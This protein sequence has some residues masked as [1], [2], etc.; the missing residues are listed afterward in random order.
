MRIESA[1]ARNLRIAAIATGLGSIVFS[2]LALSDIIHDSAYLVAGFTIPSVGL[3]CGLPVA[4]AGFARWGSVHVVRILARAHTVVT[5]LVIFL[6]VPFEQFGALPAGGAP[7]ILNTVSVAAA[8]AVVAWPARVVWAYIILMAA[9]GAALR[10]VGLGTGS[11]I[12]PLEDG[13][14]ML[15]FSVVIAT[16]LIVAL[17]I[18]RDRDSA[19]ELAIIDARSASELASRARQRSRFAALVHDDVLTTL[20]AAARSTSRTPAVEQSA[21]RAISRLDSFMSAPLSEVPLDPTIFEI[22]VRAAATDVVDGVKFEGAFH[23]FDGLIPSQVALAITGAIAEAARNSVHHAGPDPVARSLRMS[24]TARTVRVEFTDD[25]VGFDLV[26]AEKKGRFGL[27]SSIRERMLAVG[28]LATIDSGPGRGAR[29][30][31]DWGTAE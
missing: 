9:S 27:R 25:G 15:E 17:R 23:E 6:W 21:E 4:M 12:I 13:L 16:L 10:F 1:Y 5:L 18:G 26:G 8:T 11:F 3:F 2:L 19:L 14:S 24:A 22:E 31:L 20:L 30:V 28:G 29:V 7:W